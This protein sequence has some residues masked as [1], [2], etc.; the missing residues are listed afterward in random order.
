MCNQ[1]KLSKTI[2][3]EFSFSNKLPPEKITDTL[4]IKVGTSLSL[5]TEEPIKEGIINFNVDIRPKDYSELFYITF[6]I[7]FLFDFNENYDIEKSKQIL[8]DA[9]PIAYNYLSERLKKITETLCVP[10][11]DLPVEYFLKH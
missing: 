9:L 7:S 1:A 3:K 6:K 2:F 11:I 10:P 4:G 8:K 5:P